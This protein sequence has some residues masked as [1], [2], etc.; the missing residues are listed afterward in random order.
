MDCNA[1]SPRRFLYREN[2]VHLTSL[3]LTIS[4]FSFFVFPLKAYISVCVCHYLITEVS[5][6]LK[7]TAR[8]VLKM[9]RPTAQLFFFL[10]LEHE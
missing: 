5:V 1:L 9:Y 4:V 10:L 6:I 3:N 7:C 2:A 8:T